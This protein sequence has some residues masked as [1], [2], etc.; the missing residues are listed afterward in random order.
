MAQ[1][2]DHHI[3]DTLQSLIV[4]FVLAMTFRA[5]V[6]EGFVIPTGSMAPTLLGQHA[7]VHSEQT[8][9]DFVVGVDPR[10]GKDLLA[11][12]FREMP[13]PM[14]GTEHP[15]AAA[16]GSSSLKVEMGDRILVHKGL[17]LIKD[18]E[19]FDVVVFKNPTNPNG[20]DGNYIKRL[21]GLPNETIWIVDGDVFARDD[22][23]GDGRFHVQRKP[24][25]IQRAVWQPVYDSDYM[26]ARPEALRGYFRGAPWRGEGWVT[27]DVRAYRCEETAPTT[28]EFDLHLRPVDDWAMYNAL[29][30]SPRQPVYV[31][32]IRVAAAIM[33]DADGLKTTFTARV[34]NHDFEF[35][36]QGETATLRMRESV[37]E[38]LPDQGWQGP[39][40]PFE[41]PPFEAG[42]ARNVEFWIV[43]QQ[44]VLFVDDE[45]VGQ[46][47]YEW[48]PEERISFASNQ[49]GDLDELARMNPAAPPQIRWHFEGSPVT[50]HRV[51]LD[52]DLF[53][54]YDTIDARTAQRN[55]V[56]PGF[57]DLVDHSEPAFGTHPDNLAKLG[58]QHYFMLGDNST[59]STDSRLWGAPH[60]LVVEQLDPSPFV[61]HEDLLVGKAWVVYF[62]APHSLSEGGRSVIPDFG[63]LRFIR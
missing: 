33:P 49:A 24:E 38:D 22:L 51:R 36:L 19:R 1:H 54:R 15:G 5:F 20:D 53:Y 32:D 55:P 63:K 56:M 13:D 21:I 44:M 4:A 26:A 29:M 7:R 43:D 8:G 25:H 57:E 47:R 45:R 28:L 41:I 58:P 10:Y 60:P 46:F 3:V 42:L 14:L 34:R 35:S 37:W 48:T 27:R 16:G 39:P 17:Y 11:N 18:P 31:G 61:V 50:L 9:R 52:R 23:A 2:H 59:A 30:P 6:T 12:R 62:P 40:T